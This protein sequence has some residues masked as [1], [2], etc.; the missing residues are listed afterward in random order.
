[1]TVDVPKNQAQLKKL[2]ASMSDPVRTLF[3][4]LPALLDS[5]FSLHVAV[6][7][8]SYTIEEKQRLT[9]YFILA[10]VDFI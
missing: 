9:L 7:Y 6:A 4:D 10:L 8:M 3:A 1:M 2:Y 5:Q